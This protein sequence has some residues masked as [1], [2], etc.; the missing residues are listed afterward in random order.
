MWRE[1]RKQ[2]CIMELVMSMGSWDSIFLGILWSWLCL[3]EAGIPS[4]LASYGVGYAYGKLGLHL[5]WHLWSWLCLWEAGT[6]SLLAPSRDL[7]RIFLTH[8][9]NDILRTYPLT[10]ARLWLRT[11]HKNIEPLHC[12]FRLFLVP[13]KE[14]EVKRQVLAMGTTEA[15]Y[16]RTVQCSCA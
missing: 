15:T 11:T 2:G 14:T 5:S 6:L 10:S 4:L 1:E 9:G 12:S 8:T 13:R 16:V 3:W 7:W